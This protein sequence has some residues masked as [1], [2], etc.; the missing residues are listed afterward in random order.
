MPKPARSRSSRRLLALSLAA[1]LVTSIFVVPPIVAGEH[2][3]FYRV[4]T[5]WTDASS[6]K[7]AYLSL[8]NAVNQAS[9]TPGYKVFDSNGLQIW[10]EAGDAVAP[11]TDDGPK[12]PAGQ[13]AGYYYVRPSWADWRGQIGAFRNISFAQALAD[14][15]EGY[16]VFD[17]D[18]VQV[19]PL[20][21]GGSDG[22]VVDAPEAPAPVVAEQPVTEIPT[23]EIPNDPEP[24]STDLSQVDNTARGWSWLGGHRWQNTLADYDAYFMAPDRMAKTIYLTFDCGYEYNGNTAKILDI[25]KANQVK[26]SFFLND[27]FIK[28]AGGTTRR[29]A[30]EG[31]AVGNHGYNHLNMPAIL[32]KSGEGAAV[33]ELT[34]LEDHYEQVTGRELDKIYRPSSGNWSERTLAV[35]QSLGYDTYFW[36]FAY[37]D[38]NTSNQPDPAWALEQLKGAVKPGAIIELH[39]VSDTNVQI[40]AEFIQ[41][42]Q[43]QGYAFEALGQ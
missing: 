28:Y 31:H 38:W 30:D 37:R 10:P 15:N 11:A 19:H 5:E 3:G 4:R 18:G 7:G 25:L 29:M 21:A 12:V 17:Q 20:P 34:R 32:G 23:A 24:V 42:A 16:A 8:A 13:T 26:A 43:T 40:M 9:G 27:A 36:S 22:V 35:A 14:S 41:W 1:V 6:Q 33:R 2:T 39:A